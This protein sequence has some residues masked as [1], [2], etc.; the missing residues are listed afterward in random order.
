MNIQYCGPFA[1]HLYSVHWNVFNNN[2]DN[3]NNKVKYLKTQIMVL[4]ILKPYN[5]YFAALKSKNARGICLY[6][7]SFKTIVHNLQ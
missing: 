6:Y 3:N 4:L 1:R 5:E 2:N 7:A